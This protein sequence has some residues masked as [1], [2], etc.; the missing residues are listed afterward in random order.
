M[1]DKVARA[2]QCPGGGAGLEKMAGQ[3]RANGEVT[4]GS[5]RER[6]ERGL[7]PQGDP[8][9]YKISVPLEHERR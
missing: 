4:A 7:A 9:A 2:L 3:V 8:E 1:L 5:E 6:I